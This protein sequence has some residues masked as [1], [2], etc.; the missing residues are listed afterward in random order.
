VSLPPEIV[1]LKALAARP[2]FR[3]HQEKVYQRLVTDT[4]PL[5]DE[6]LQGLAFGKHFL[7]DVPH[8]LLAH[9]ALFH[10][11]LEPRKLFSVH[12]SQFR[13]WHLQNFTLLLGA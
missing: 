10:A 8:G 6:V 2:D 5:L 11:F 4:S 3:Q 9:F 12:C 13:T 1:G 7:F